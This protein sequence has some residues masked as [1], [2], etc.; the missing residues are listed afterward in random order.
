MMKSS[1]TQDWVSLLSEL[2]KLPAS[3]CQ[4]SKEISETPL[5]SVVL[6]HYNRPHLLKL[7][8]ASLEAQ[9]YKNFEVVL[10]DDGSTDPEAIALLDDLSWKWWEEKGWKVIREPNR[11][12]GASRNTGV[13]HA[14]GQ[15]VLFMD[16]DDYAKPH[17]IETFVRVATATKSKVMTSGHDIFSGT[18]VPL[19]QSTHRYTPLGG[20][21][22]AGM[23]ENVY[24]DSAMFIERNYFIESGGFTED[25]GVGF[26]DYEYLAKVALRGDVIE[27]ISEPL[28][29]YRLH[30]GTM[31]ESTR[32]KANQL[33]MLRAYID[34]N[35]ISD[36]IQKRLLMHVQKSFFESTDVGAFRRDLGFLNGDLKRLEELG[37]NSTDPVIPFSFL[38][39]FQTQLPTSN[40]CPDTT[41]GCL[42]RVIDIN[43][44]VVPNTG[45][46]SVSIIGFNFNQIQIELEDAFGKKYSVASFTKQRDTVANIDYLV[47]VIPKVDLRQNYYGTYTVS[48]IQNFYKAQFD[49]TIYDPAS[50]RILVQ[51]YPVKIF[52]DSLSPVYFYIG[53]LI[54]IP[55]VEPYCVYNIVT[56]FGRTLQF[57]EPGV[58]DMVLS[59]VTCYISLP[60]SAAVT[61]DLIYSNVLNYRKLNKDAYADLVKQ[62]TLP[63]QPGTQSGVIRVF[64]RAPVMASANLTLSTYVL[65]VEFT[66]PFEIVR[67]SPDMTSYTV[68]DAFNTP[69]NCDTLFITKPN[70]AAGSELLSA[71]SADCKATQSGGTTLS[72][73]FNR[74]FMKKYTS[75][76]IKGNDTL[77]MMS[78]R[79]RYMGAQYSELNATDIVIQAQGE[80]TLPKVVADITT[81]VGLCTGFT[82]DL[83]NTIATAMLPLTQV[84]V[85]F[86]PVDVAT[87]DASVLES[88]MT[89]L[90]VAAE[91]Q[92]AKMLTDGKPIIEFTADFL[93]SL[94]AGK[95]LPDGQ[96]Q[97]VVTATNFIGGQVSATF[98]F[99]R[100]R[101][102]VAPSIAING[103]LDGQAN[104]WADNSITAAISASTSSS[105]AC[106]ANNAYTYTWI[107][108]GKTAKT[109]AI[110]ALPLLS[111][112]PY[113]LLPK[114]KYNATVVVSNAG[115]SYSRSYI[116]NTAVDNI[117]VSAGSNRVVGRGQ[118]LK[119]SANIVDR[120][121]SNVSAVPFAC[122]WACITDSGEDCINLKTTAVFSLKTCAADLT[123]VFGV[124]KYVLSVTVTNPSTGSST[125]SNP[126]IIE[127]IRDK[128]P[129]VALQAS[130]ISPSAWDRTFQITAI[131][132]KTTVSS[133]SAIRYRW[134]STPVCASGKSAV[135]VDLSDP[136]N[137]AIFPTRDILKFKVDALKPGSTYCFKVQIVDGATQ[138]SETEFEVNVRDRPS[139][140]FCAAAGYNTANDSI[141]L[142]EFSDKLSISCTGWQTDSLSLPLY[143]VA[144]VKKDDGS[145]SWSGWRTVQ[146]PST[147]TFSDIFLAAGNY[148]ARMN[149]TDAAG[150]LPS[151]DSQTIFRVKVTSAYTNDATAGL[152]NVR[153][154]L[155]AQKDAALKG[156]DITAFMSI[157][158]AVA[159]VG[160]DSVTS[161]AHISLQQDLISSLAYLQSSGNVVLDDEGTTL[162]SG[163]L[164]AAIGSGCS[165]PNAN[166]VAATDTLTSLMRTSK[167]TVVGRGEALTPS[168]LDNL[169]GTMNTLMCAATNGS[170]NA[171][172]LSKT[173][174]SFVYNIAQS[175]LSTAACGETAYSSN[176]PSF[177]ITT[178]VGASG[179]SSYGLFSFGSVNTNALAPNGCPPFVTGKKASNLFRGNSVAI[180]SAVHQ[181]TFL[182]STGFTPS[183]PSG[184]D[185]TFDIPVTAS[186]ID[187]KNT[188]CGFVVYSDATENVAT[189]TVAKDGC[190]S[191]GVFTVGDQ[192]VVRC[193]CNH[194]TDFLIGTETLTIAPAAPSPTPAASGSSSVGMIVGIVV[195]VLVVIGA[196]GGFLYV[197]NRRG[198]SVAYAR[199]TQM[200]QGQAPA[201][202]PASA[203]ARPEPSALPQYQESPGYE[204]EKKKKKKKKK[205][206]DQ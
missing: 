98:E 159:E 145:P 13:K 23:L 121:Y 79:V 80:I 91:T 92:L 101:G 51:D 44:S 112:A 116:F 139:H 105:A 140:G 146:L 75:Q 115:K 38:P 30:S 171:D 179:T 2:E 1:G 9:T 76:L 97:A 28:H 84:T 69:V 192:T 93:E 161:P 190:S 90:N 4:A 172:T 125:T 109:V 27:A 59:R 47:A 6:V 21:V 86:S 99:S 169:V 94:Y 71:N 185:V 143:Y 113:T 106:Q 62:F 155:A 110:S 132:D 156:G 117:Q 130:K 133:L 188:T 158:S 22:L 150:G 147:S 82:L 78:N 126:S 198:P 197:R 152:N 15:Y 36:K 182:N 20:A 16:D 41:I 141:S 3:T 42:Q 131:V 204:T 178:G 96:Y 87:T 123:D 32:L 104:V 45:A 119:I 72:I 18:S 138:S 83:S 56:P 12:L 95:P 103:P 168:S 114:E 154:V 54:D 108:Q 88:M 164:K 77:R 111:V 46:A 102:S 203:N 48:V 29:W 33:R 175:A 148:L 157:V 35:W 25:F 205:K 26:E 181:M 37:S 137:M 128:L 166:A 66:L 167:A 58:Y 160:F 31:S 65:N 134:T 74:D 107:F 193:Q 100:Q 186:A 70:G 43:P 129:L 142:R 63:Y 136:A 200:E 177:S 162:I 151:S 187:G 73:T 10:V 194:L 39:E 17:Q 176:N 81:A 165:I 60:Y 135:V 40:F 53:E 124:G 120:S 14:T 85:L 191:L 184:V 183:M 149:V 195:G 180:A 163:Q 153:S 189:S 34:G 52:T 19:G 196:I 67:Y 11:Y 174:N 201:A 89:V 8:I 144:E 50:S 7:A 122:D 206:A 57:A 118:T 49:I 5:V 202:A 170:S 173:I 199:E 64:N 24:G 61:I 68:F 55:V 127:I